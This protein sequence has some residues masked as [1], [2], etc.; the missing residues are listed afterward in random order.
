MLNDRFLRLP[1]G[2]DR[3]HSS[4]YFIGQSKL[5]VYALF[6]AGKDTVFIPCF[7]KEENWNICDN[8]N[9]SNISNHVY[10]FVFCILSS[11]F[12]E[13]YAV[14]STFLSRVLY[15]LISWNGYF[16]TCLWKCMNI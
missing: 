9:D 6:Q 14:L 16:I 15:P 7:P 1:S 3:Y 4:S 5:L 10:I 8:S 13:H 2:G 11:G 12:S